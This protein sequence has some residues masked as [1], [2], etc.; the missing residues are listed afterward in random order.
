MNAPTP[1][2]TTLFKSFRNM[3]RALCSVPV[4]IGP[5]AGGA[6]AT[7]SFGS[8]H[9]P[10][11]L[12]RIAQDALPSAA[13]RPQIMGVHLCVADDAASGLKTAEQKL[14]GGDAAPPARAVLIEG[15]EI[16]R[17]ADAVDQIAASPAMQGVGPLTIGLYR[18]EMERLSVETVG[19]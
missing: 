14:R 5:G 8:G 16:A 3:Q 15:C 2:S 1:W 19:A 4:S 12:E 6:L 11:L 17:V 9:E 7:I 13:A 10:A 18:L